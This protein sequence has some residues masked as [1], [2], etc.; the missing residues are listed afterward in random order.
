MQLI[1]M[2]RGT[3]KTLTAMHARSGSITGRGL[4][5]CP[6]GDPEMP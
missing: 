1:S 5:E 4:P 2:Y 3:P 6:F